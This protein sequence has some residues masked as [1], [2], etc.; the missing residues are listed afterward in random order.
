[1]FIEV[2]PMGDIGGES[3]ESVARYLTQLDTANRQKP[4]EALA[5]KTTR[6]AM[7][8]PGQA[9]RRAASR[10]TSLSGPA[11]SNLNC[12]PRRRS[13]SSILEGGTLSSRKRELT[14]RHDDFARAPLRYRS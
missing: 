6:L 8:S 4:S 3:Q 2:M 13:P 5:T 9:Q 1:V 10:V 12:S 7:I 14:A 11:A